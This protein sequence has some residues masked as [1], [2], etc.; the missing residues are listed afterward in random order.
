MIPRLWYAEV[1]SFGVR[2]FVGGVRQYPAKCFS[3]GETI[4]VRIA[5]REGGHVGGQ[6]GAATVS[7]PHRS[8]FLS[9]RAGAVGLSLDNAAGL[10]RDLSALRPDVGDDLYGDTQLR[11][12]VPPVG[13][14]LAS[15]F[16]NSAER[17]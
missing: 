17:P 14:Q 8:F 7:E 2:R 10:D 3:L 11:S 9:S 15:G 6:S 13:A 12:V 5:H 16:E 1:R 4:G